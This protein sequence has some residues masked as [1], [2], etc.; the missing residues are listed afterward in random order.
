MASKKKKG[1]GSNVIPLHPAP[2]KKAKRKKRAKKKKVYGPQPP[3]FRQLS[4]FEIAKMRAEDPEFEALMAK[5]WA[6]M[7]AGDDE[8]LEK[9][10]F[11][12]RRYDSKGRRI[13]SE[14]EK[15]SK[16]ARRREQSAFRRRKKKAEAERSVKAEAGESPSPITAAKIFDLAKHRPKKP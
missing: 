10:G 7:S 8:E 13:Y 11:K 15:A 4:E 5:A 12:V 1:K 2:R 9:E 3:L 6:K 16:K 14:K